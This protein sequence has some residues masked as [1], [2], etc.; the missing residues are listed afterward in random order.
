MIRVVLDANVLVSGVP[1]VSGSL[2]ELVNL[3]RANQFEV[4]S[5]RHI[6]DEIGRAWTKPYWRAR[7][8]PRQAEGALQLI[9]RDTTVA[10]ITVRVDGVATHV[11][12]DLVIATAVSGNADYL[13][14][15]DLGLRRSGRTMGLS[16]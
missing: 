3:W 10:A 12:D 16:F 9:Q 15:G 4:I 11:E 7:L 5:S 8:S 2:A 14:T 13:V 6:I 1:A